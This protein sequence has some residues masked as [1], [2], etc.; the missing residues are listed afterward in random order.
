MKNL[1]CGRQPVKEALL[2]GQPLERLY[3]ADTVKG[4]DITEIKRL[5]LERE[6]RFDF[7][8][9]AKIN[10]LLGSHDHQG[11]AAAVSAV[12]YGDLEAFLRETAGT[13][14]LTLVILDE[15][16]SPRNVGLIA[17]TAVGAGA[18]G[19]L[20]CKRGGAGVDEEVVR[21]SA[22]VVYRL[23]LFKVANLVQA[24]DRLKEHGF[25]IYGL[26]AHG[27]TD[28]FAA[29]WPE[30]VALVL[31]NEH[32]GLRRLVRERCDELVRIPLDGGI[33]SLN[34]AVAAGIALFQV[35]RRW[36][37]TST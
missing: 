8:P 13:V 28:L 37:V 31:G 9:I 16:H 36:R 7:V 5:A 21:A 30:R 29:N 3:L 15:I 24:L 4:R 19:M 22:G 35:G 27:P 25:W 12:Q 14:P 18:A 23:P 26:D 32:E 2:S 1:I 17:R 6:V 20:L 33:D 34:V 10:K 11:V